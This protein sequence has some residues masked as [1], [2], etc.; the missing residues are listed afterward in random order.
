MLR[1]VTAI[2]GGRSHR[3]RSAAAAK[4]TERPKLQDFS[5]RL[6]QKLTQPASLDHL[7]GIVRSAVWPIS[8]RAAH[9]NIPTS[10]PAAFGGRVSAEGKIAAEDYPENTVKHSEACSGVVACLCNVSEAMSPCNPAM[11]MSIAL[12]KLSS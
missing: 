12:S 11:N 5:H 2:T 10:D 4:C 8:W 6:G 1:V 9:H 3:I 7:V